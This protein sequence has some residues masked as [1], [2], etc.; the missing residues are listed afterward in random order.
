MTS[1]HGSPCKIEVVVEQIYPCPDTILVFLDQRYFLGIK[2]QL[3]ST[4]GRRCFLGR[5]N[6]RQGNDW[7]V[8]YIPRW[9]WITALPSCAGWLGWFSGT[10]VRR[11]DEI[12]RFAFKIESLT[13]PTARIFFITFCMTCSARNTDGKALVKMLSSMNHGL[14]Q[15]TIV[16]LVNTWTNMDWRDDKGAN[17]TYRFCVDLLFFWLKQPPASIKALGSDIEVLVLWN[18]CY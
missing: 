14:S 2:R 3:F 8:E 15:L 13:S 4:I 11:N 12:W 9:C 5:Y 17:E 7:V 18:R 16:F 6:S 1:S 10:P